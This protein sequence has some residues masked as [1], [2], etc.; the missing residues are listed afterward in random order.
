MEGTRSKPN[1][2]AEKSPQDWNSF[3]IER[4]GE[5]TEEQIEKFKTSRVKPEFQ[6]DFEEQSM[7]VKTGLV[8]LDKL[9]DQ[10]LWAFINY[11]DKTLKGEKVDLFIP[12]LHDVITKIMYL[13]I[14]T[15]RNF[16]GK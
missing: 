4:M 10:E 14:F 16:V 3:F 6:K 11:R 1:K 8:V 2:D 7:E 13:Q 5:V 15:G 12:G 9:T